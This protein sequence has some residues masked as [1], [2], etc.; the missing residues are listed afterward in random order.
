LYRVLGAISAFPVQLLFSTTH[1]PS[2][3]PLARKILIEVPR[4]LGT[5]VTT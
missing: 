3:P 5:L 2:A 4:G 1:T